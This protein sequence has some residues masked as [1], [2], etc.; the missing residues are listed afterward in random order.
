[1]RMCGRSHVRMGGGG[2]PLCIPVT[3]AREGCRTDAGTEN[4]CGDWRMRPKGRSLQSFSPRPPP[5]HP[6]AP[7]A[8]G[9]VT[10]HLCGDAA[11]KL[12]AKEV[13]GRLQNLTVG[14]GGGEGRG[15]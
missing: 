12:Q 8:A 3:M 6:V 14:S 5:R 15:A 7:G 10:P 11:A 2:K 9:T 13:G 1:M 4:R